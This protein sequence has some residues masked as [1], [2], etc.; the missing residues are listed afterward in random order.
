MQGTRDVTAIDWL[1][2]C[3]KTY[4]KSAANIN[5]GVID[6]F[7]RNHGLT[8]TKIIFKTWEHLAGLNW[9]SYE[10]R[11]DKRLKN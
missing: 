11:H 3:W 6:T 10:D 1:N 5:Q 9:Y 7:A 8:T 2:R 4:V